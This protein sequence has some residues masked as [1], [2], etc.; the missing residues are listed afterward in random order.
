MRLLKD[1]ADSDDLDNFSDQF[2]VDI[3]F[4]GTKLRN[5]L[6]WRG[7]LPYTLYAVLTM[8]YYMKI[9][10]NEDL[11]EKA[12]LVKSVQAVSLLYM[13]FLEFN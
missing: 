1:L 3:F 9:F 13:I 5:Q 6:I 10:A 7:L 12:V 2:F 4:G 8:V 11:A